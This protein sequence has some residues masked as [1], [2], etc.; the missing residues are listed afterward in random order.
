MI[1]ELKIIVWILTGLCFSAVSSQEEFA[2]EV[3]EVT[4]TVSDLNA[5]INFYTDVLSF[6]KISIDTL[7]NK[8]LNALFNLEYEGLKVVKAKLQIGEEFIQLMQF[9]QPTDG[10]LIPED[11]QSNDLWFQHIAIV[12]N[13]MDKAYA[14]LKKHKVV[15]VSTMP[16]ELPEY[17]P[18]A[19]GIKAFY[20]R[21]PDGH[22]LEV[23]Y[24]PKDKGNPKWQNNTSNSPFIGI[25]HTAIGVSDTDVGITY[26]SDIL[27]LDV[28]GNSTNYGPEQEHL[29]QVFGAHLLITGLK[30]TKGFGIEFLQYIAPPGGRVYPED[31]EVTDLWHWHT[32]IKVKNIETLFKELMSQNHLEIISTRITISKELKLGGNKAFMARDPDGH[33]LLFVE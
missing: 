32:T 10:K 33:A 14:I 16:Q 8:E 3:K 25:D 5:S 9:I 26:Y 31:S 13:D 2:Q 19:A 4:M 6:K 24:F 1:K 29:N 12:V 15:H 30:A 23:I 18:A 20:F 28:A 22:N 21:D 11:S 7:Q 17:I 27:G